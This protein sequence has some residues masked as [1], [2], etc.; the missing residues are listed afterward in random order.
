MSEPEDIISSLLSKENNNDPSAWSKIC[1]GLTISKDTTTSSNNG[2]SSPMKKIKIDKASSERKRQKL[3]SHGYSLIDETFDMDLVGC[4]RKGIEQLFHLG[5][6]ATCILLFDEAWDLARSSRTA[7]DQCTHNQNQLNFDLLAWYIKAGTS[8]FSP[9]RDRQPENAKDT[10]HSDDQAKFVTQW[11]ALSDA[12]TENSCLH[13]IP[14]MDDPGYAEGDKD[15][16]DPMIR[17]LPNKESYQNIRALPRKAG[18]SIMFTHRIIHWGSR[19]DA[20]LTGAPRIAIS[21]V[22]SDPSYEPPLVDPQHFTAEKNPPFRI[23]LLL[24]CAQ[25]LIY[26]QRFELTKEAVKCCYKFCKEHEDD[27]DESYRHKVFVEFVN[28]MKETSETTDNNEGNGKAAV[29]LVVT[30]EGDEEDEE[31]AMMQE[32][33]DAEE[34][35]YGEFKDDFDEL[36]GEEE[37]DSEGSVN[38]KDDYEDDE[39][40][41]VNLFGKRKLEE[42]KEANGSAKRQK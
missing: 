1:P 32:M 33:L 3:V 25:L 21:F 9:H 24:V 42:T 34:G 14:K 30:E 37:Y 8:G 20:D 6:P 31:D 26:Y 4:L 23:R 7:L 38:N 39:D 15:D 19:S 40:D 5:L 18:Q 16:Q 2:A 17:A 27:L 41:E 35:G 11:I 22:S 36:D 29:E 12:T 10:F 28:A 13:V